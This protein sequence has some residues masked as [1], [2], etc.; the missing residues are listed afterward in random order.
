MSEKLTIRNF[1][2][3][4]NVELDFKK[5]NVII[6]ENATGKST[7]AKVLA[8]CRYFSFIVKTQYGILDNFL[9]NDDGEHFLEGLRLWGMQEF[10]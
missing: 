10:L 7:V 4:K 1:G 6:G 2:P 5:F 9:E 3:I 8:V